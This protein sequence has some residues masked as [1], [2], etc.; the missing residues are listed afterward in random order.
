MLVTVVIPVYNSEKY[1]S[2][3]IYS[4]INQSYQ[5]IEII[6][7][8]DC[9]T[10]GSL[11]IVKQLKS[12]YPIIRVIAFEENLGVAHARNK[13]IDVAKGQFIAFIDADDLWKPDKL[14]K[15]VS[16]MLENKYD[17]TFTSYEYISEEGV[18]KNKIVKVPERI[19][20][21]QLLKNHII[22]CSTVVINIDRIGKFQ[23]PLLRK[24]QDTATWLKLLK[25]MDFAYG[26]DIPL[27]AY[28]IRTDSLSNNKFKAI[29]R[30]WILF[31]R[32]ENKAFFTSL[33]LLIRHI[34]NAVKKRV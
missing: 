22:G 14:E 27:M 19:N 12:E 15:Q 33:Y 25:T 8:D 32:S 1:I 4:V 3:T 23:M 10:D 6:V 30:T 20:Y 13:G 11:E 26:I 28:R 31:R 18:Y 5:D 16:F 24:G 7:V 34:I 9:S 21:N 17:F 29:H 2:K